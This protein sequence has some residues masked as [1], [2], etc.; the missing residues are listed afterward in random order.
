MDFASPP[1]PLTV[2]GD[3]FSQDMS[4]VLCK[5]RQSTDRDGWM[6]G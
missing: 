3:D 4:A 5:G 6:D 2:F 1:P